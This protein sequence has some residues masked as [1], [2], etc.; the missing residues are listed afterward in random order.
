MT[1][2]QTIARE[3]TSRWDKDHK[4]DSQQTSNAHVASVANKKDSNA[5]RDNFRQQILSQP[6]GQSGAQQEGQ[7]QR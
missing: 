6:S 7:M 4:A 2:G 5:K 3:I 1:Y